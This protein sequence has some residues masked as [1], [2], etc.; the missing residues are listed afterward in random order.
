MFVAVSNLTF[1]ENTNAI[2]VVLKSP[3]SVSLIPKF[4]FVIKI[5]IK[6]ETAIS[7]I[8]LFNLKWQKHLEKAF[9]QNTK[10]FNAP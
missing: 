3:A 2:L 4:S 1:E 10:I 8:S 6:I 7:N 5:K 9:L